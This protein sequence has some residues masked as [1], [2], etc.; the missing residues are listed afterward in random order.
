[1]LH[2]D[3]KPNGVSCCYITDYTRHEDL[4]ILSE[5]H[6]RP[7]GLERRIVKVIL[8]DRQIEMAKIIRAGEF[9]TIRNLRLLVSTTEDHVQG[10]LGGAERLINKLRV[11]DSANERLAVLLRWV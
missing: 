3:Y 9:Y 2:V 8:W 6:T 10:R 7:Q 4:P 5:M 11:E 1:M